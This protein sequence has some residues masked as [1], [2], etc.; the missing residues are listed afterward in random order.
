MSEET[1][2]ANTRRT[3][4]IS[5]TTASSFGN[6]KANNKPTRRY[7]LSW[8]SL[9]IVVL[10]LLLVSASCQP[11]CATIPNADGNPSPDGTTC[12]CIGDTYWDYDL[13]ECVVDCSAVTNTGTDEQLSACTCA[14]GY[15]WSP[16]TRLCV[17]DCENDDYSLGTV[18][19]N[20]RCNCIED[21]E[22]NDAEAKCKIMCNAVDKGDQ[23][24]AGTVD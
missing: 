16:P 8:N 24:V 3:S 7:F 4:A 13:I 21:F 10:S 6:G 18:D 5:T 1:F 11:D 23:N 14:A 12:N 17:A 20:G 19:V 15:T 9:T 2:D 22:F